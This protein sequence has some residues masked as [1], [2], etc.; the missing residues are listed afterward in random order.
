MKILIIGNG[1]REHALAW[2]IS[3]DPKASQ[4]F[5]APGNG[6]TADMDAKTQ[7][8]DIK[9]K[10]IDE[11]IAFSKK[12]NI[13]LVVV[14]PEQPLELG[15]V[16]A[17]EKEG[18]KIFG[19]SK[20]AARL[21]TSK[22]YAKNLMKHLNIPSAA[23][24]I[25]R[26]HPEASA[27]F[28][29]QEQYPQVIKASGLAGGKGVTIAENKAEAL[30]TL[31]DLFEKRKHGDAANEVVVE[32]FMIGEEASIFAITDGTS[33]KLLSTAQDHKRIGE[34]DTGKNTGGMGAYAPAPVVTQEV[35]DKVC[36]K[37]ID[38]LLTCMRREGNPY[39]GFL[40]I[41]LMI[42]KSEPKV[43][44]F[45]ARLGDP[46]AQV[47]L[48]LLE[49]SLLDLILATVDGRLADED[50]ALSVKSAATVVMASEGYPESYPTGMEI[51]GLEKAAGTPD[52][53]VFH[54]GTAQK[55]NHL[56]TSGGR[57]LSVTSMSNT[58]KDALSQAYA[59]VGEINFEGAYF[60]RDIGHR[61]L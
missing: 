44:E 50:I 33:Y 49:T 15:I 36:K 54:A 55:N 17:F 58:L 48:P 56:L 21:E 57:V 11:L 10:D 25:F 30:M 18:I 16:N 59:G 7:N 40:Y 32:E 47:V 20:E 42:Q 53:M 34:G 61:A 43:V 26:T 13:D 4:I 35:L 39:K 52:V 46:E 23:Y 12:E 14:G 8:V 19:P 28:H 38:P 60:R 2:S 51:T 37:I 6:G 3:K 22:S 29:E 31:V 45:N 1:A 9:A 24:L 5:V 27:Y 41:G